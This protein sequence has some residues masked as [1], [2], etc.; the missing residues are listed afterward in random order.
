MISFATRYRIE[1]AVKFGRDWAIPASAVK[2][3]DERNTTGECRD[4]RKKQGG[5][6]WLYAIVYS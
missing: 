2:P 5:V 6:L 3:S 1:G 4:W